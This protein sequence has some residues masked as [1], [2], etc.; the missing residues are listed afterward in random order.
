MG[1]LVY[2]I[3]LILCTSCLPLDNQSRCS[4]IFQFRPSGSGNPLNR[5]HPQPIFLG[6]FRC[7]RFF[8]HPTAV[9]VCCCLAPGDRKSAKANVSGGFGE[10]ATGIS[11]TSHTRE[12]ESV[13]GA[14]TSSAWNN[15][16]SLSHRRCNSAPNIS[17]ISSSSWRGAAGL[18]CPS[19]G[20][21]APD[22]RDHTIP[23]GRRF[24]VR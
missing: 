7:V 21:V 9:L 3:I 16:M 4:L 13:G 19:S 6:C 14:A 8:F 23:E 12:H 10:V 17:S 5:K 24:E 18:P 1:T 11:T 22:L 2:C 20:T 15:S